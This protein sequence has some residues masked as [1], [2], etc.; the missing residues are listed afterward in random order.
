MLKTLKTL[1]KQLKTVISIPNRPYPQITAV[2]IY[3]KLINWKG[4]L[5]SKHYHSN[6]IA[7]ATRKWQIKL[8]QQVQLIHIAQ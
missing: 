2:A 5:S 8:D 6:R 1:N 3:N 7:A 4:S